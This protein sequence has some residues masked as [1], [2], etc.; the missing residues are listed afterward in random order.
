M[1][2]ITIGRE[3][4]SGGRELGKRLAEALGYA[5]YDEEIIGAIAR[6]SGLAEEYVK[7]VVENAVPQAYPITYGRTL[8]MLSST[9]ENHMTILRAQEEVLRELARKK[10][11]VIV[12]RCADVLLKDLK[13][14][15]LFV[16][17]DMDSKIKRCRFKAAVDEKLT[18]K[19]LAKLIKKTEKQRRSYYETITDQ[20]WGAK[21]N[22]HLCINTSGREVNGKEI[23][24]QIPAIAAFCRAWFGEH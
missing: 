2:V 10:N 21:E 22:Y 4:G 14:L 9:S 7:S 12:G 24:V 16:H 8:G 18:D 3:F 23:K 19:E 11:C 1:N 15:N 17:A 20:R 13:P 5:Y 6:K